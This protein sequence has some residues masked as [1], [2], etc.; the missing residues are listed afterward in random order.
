MLSSV[1]NPSLI[2]IIYLS[3]KSK[4]E[5]TLNKY[6]NLRG[7][8]FLGNWVLMKITLYGFFNMK[9]LVNSILTGEYR[10]VIK[11]SFKDG[12]RHTYVQEKMDAFKFSRYVKRYHDMEFSVGE[13]LSFSRERESDNNRPLMHRSR[14]RSRQHK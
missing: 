9:Q 10:Q 5:I 8:K 14:L 3:I 1:N 4:N 6:D 7:I 12:P 13:E 2:S 11:K